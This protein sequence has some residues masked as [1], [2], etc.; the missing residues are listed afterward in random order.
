MTQ[1]IWKN[2][3]LPS[4][5]E[6][7][8]HEL[9]HENSK[10]GRHTQHPCTEDVVDQL[11][12]LHPSLPYEGL[13]RI[14]LPRPNLSPDISFFQIVQSRTSV[15]AFRPSSISLQDVGTLLF[16]AYGVTRTCDETNLP[17]GFRVVP[18]GGGL[19]PLEIY[20]HSAHLTEHEPGMFHYNPER[21]CLHR[22]C[23]GD[24]TDTIANAMVQ[25]EIGHN[26]SLLVFITAL[27]ERATFK[28]QDRGYRFSLIE[29]GHVAQNL[30]LAANALN[31]GSVNIGGF[32]DRE[33]EKLLGIDGVAHSILYMVAIGRRQENA[34]PQ[35]NSVTE[36][37]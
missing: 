3:V 5:N 23:A 14:D 20:L 13:P 34:L 8:L 29:A 22:I 10:L 19:Y 37:H 33:I 36:Q 1:P 30:N 6:D 28:Y 4:G 21:C 7:L 2:L 25:P 12:S 31:L 32:F 9:F 24:M 15:R 11:Q 18:S 26:A 35:N 27:F 16:C 17:R